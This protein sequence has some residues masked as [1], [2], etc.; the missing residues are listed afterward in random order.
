MYS[1]TSAQLLLAG[2]A[3]TTATLTRSSTD[4][5]ATVVNFRKARGTGGS[6][7]AVVSNDAIGQ[8]SYLAYDGSAFVNTSQT[9]GSVETFTGVG[10]V[11]GFLNFSTRPTGS[12]AA[13]TERMRINSSG[14][15][16]IGT[17]SPSSTFTVGGNPPTAGKASVVGTTGGVSLALSD[18]VNSSLYVKHSTSGFAIVG[19]DSGGGLMFGTNGFTE[20]MR[21]DSSG[22]VGIGAT[23]PGVLLDVRN[24]SN[25][26]GSGTWL[27][28]VHQNTNTSGFN[29][30]SVMNTWAASTS[31]VLE[32]A[33]AWNGTTTGYYP[34]FQIDGIN[35]RFS[36]IYGS[37]GTAAV[38]TLY[39][40]FQCRAW[41]NFNGT[42]T[43]AIV[44]SGNVTSITDNAVGDYTVNF[45]TAMPDA[46][47]AVNGMTTSNASSNN[48]PLAIYSTGNA[49]TG[50]NTATTK[51][52]SALR[53]RNAGA[54]NT[55]QFD[56]PEISV[57]IFR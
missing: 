9:R 3:T 31:K 36:A 47:Y 7:L 25:T 19:T 26:G 28:K 24:G 22:N 4:A 11:S 10:N 56:C 6:Q 34:I 40:E 20:R 29:G 43:V 51:T 2:D 23:S 39:P 49:S 30:L 41:V 16:G 55:T 14:N 57:A 12:S 8:S 35:Q 18:N 45:T 50:S 5:N 1:A 52:T 37:G 48:V 33:V 15:V 44:G 54:N 13:L 46:N 17:T 42:G 21:I 32:L 27:T 53:V 38:A